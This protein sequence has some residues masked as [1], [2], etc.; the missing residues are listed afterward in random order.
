MKTLEIVKTIMVVLVAT[1][2][3]AEVFI[4]KMGWDD[5]PVDERGVDYENQ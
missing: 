3:A 2:A 4:F 1:A 5:K